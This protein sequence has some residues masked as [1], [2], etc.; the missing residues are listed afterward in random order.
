MDDIYPFPQ[1]PAPELLHKPDLAAAAIRLLEH[2][3]PMVA[4]NIF[5]GEK[6]P[7]I[8]DNLRK[9]A[10]DTDSEHICYSLTQWVQEEISDAGSGLTTWIEGETGDKGL[11]SSV[12]YSALGVCAKLQRTRVAWIDWMIQELKK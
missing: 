7:F 5:L 10:I 11:Y 2:I 12:M 3:R 4:E 6:S 8:C 1:T 9:F